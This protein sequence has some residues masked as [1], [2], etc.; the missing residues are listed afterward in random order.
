MKKT[1]QD[2][3]W[4]KVSK[5]DGCWLW[6]G[7]LMTSGYG[8][9]WV[10]P[11]HG[12]DGAHRVSFKIAYGDFDENLYVLHNC[13]VKKCVRPDHLFLGTQT[14][15]MRDCAAKGG[16]KNCYRWT[17]ENNP[18]AGKPMPDHLKA[19][20]SERKKKPFKFIDPNGNQ[21]SGVNLRQFCLTHGLNSGAMWSVSVGN[22]RIHKGYTR[23]K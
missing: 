11:G 19:A 4:E 16:L 7:C 10:G 6:V 2:R 21:I 9:F 8:S 3:F 22:V 17:K 5:T 20:M 12:K 13:D 18:N 23:A 15:N 14:D 1:L